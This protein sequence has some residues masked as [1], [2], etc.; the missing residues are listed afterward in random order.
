MRHF[1]IE[2]FQSYT[3]KT[4]VIRHGY[5]KA[6]STERFLEIKGRCGAL[7]NEASQAV[8]NFQ[9]ELDEAAGYKGAPDNH[10]CYEIWQEWNDN[11]VAG[12]ICR[13]LVFTA[14]FHDDY[15]YFGKGVKVENW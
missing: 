11:A 14:L 12:G 1:V 13:E 6:T 10:C 3:K 5:R 8:S 7:G 15:V 9:A 4:K 2:L